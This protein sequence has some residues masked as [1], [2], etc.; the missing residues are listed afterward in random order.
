MSE[1]QLQKVVS[2]LD[3][4]KAELT[5]CESAQSTSTACAQLVDFSEKEGGPEP[6]CAGGPENVWQSN[7]GGGGGCVIL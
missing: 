3:K 7:Q 4:L 1:A 6:F 2:E 5:Q